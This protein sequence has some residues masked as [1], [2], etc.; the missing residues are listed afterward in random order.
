MNARF[1][2]VLTLAAVVVCGPVSGQE[3]STGSIVAVGQQTIHKSPEQIIVAVELIARSRDLAKA[4]QILQERIAAAKSQVIALGA[5][6]EEIHV[7]RVEV[8]SNESDAMNQLSANVQEGYLDAGEEEAA[9]AIQP[10]TTLT[11]AFVAA[12]DVR[13]DDSIAQLQQFAERA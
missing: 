8:S 13:S 9:A 11:A 10:L 5:S 12:F 2:R 7:D 6:A 1:I 3:S 4:G